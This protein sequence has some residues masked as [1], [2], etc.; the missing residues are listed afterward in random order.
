MVLRNPFS[1]RPPPWKQAL[2]ESEPAGGTPPPDHQA[3]AGTDDVGDND[4]TLIKS[5]PPE[6]GGPVRAVDQ[7]QPGDLVSLEQL[8]QA[9]AA[10]DQPL[11][12]Q[13]PPSTTVRPSADK[14]LRRG[15]VA[16]PVLGA[17]MDM[18]NSSPEEIYRNPDPL[19]ADLN[20]ALEEARDRLAMVKGLMDGR[21]KAIQTSKDELRAA[22]T[23]IKRRRAQQAQTHEQELG[24]LQASQ[25]QERHE[26]EARIAR[27]R[28]DLEER[29]A[30][31]R[32]ELRSEH[33]QAQRETEAEHTRERAEYDAKQKE[34][35]DAL[36]AEQREAEQEHNE[37]KAVLEGELASASS[38]LTKVDGLMS[39][40]NEAAFFARGDNYNRRTAPPPAASEPPA[41]DDEP[42]VDIEP[43]VGSVAAAAD[44][45]E[46][47][48]PDGNDDEI[49]DDGIVPGPTT[50]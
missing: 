46:G 24:S 18:P 39:E 27:E 23:D 2:D 44:G 37:T 35:S 5:R 29:Y 12:A 41:V 4:P 32:D 30:R 6:T 3:G 38:L 49:P 22:K 7:R 20:R 26:L 28:Q 45:F 33:E 8:A 14:A 1:K 19:P 25:R 9:A 10:G 40:L 15:G 13:V 47:E 48:V 36:N 11:A 21:R 43:A 16:S 34:L 31:E 50:N 17:A 42:A